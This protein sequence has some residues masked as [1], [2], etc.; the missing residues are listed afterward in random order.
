MGNIQTFIPQD[1]F[2]LILEYLKTFEDIEFH[3]FHNIACTSRFFSKLIPIKLLKCQYDLYYPFQKIKLNSKQIAEYMKQEKR[4]GLVNIIFLNDNKMLGGLNIGMYSSNMNGVIFECT[5]YDAHVRIDS[6][7]D[8]KVLNK[9][10]SLSCFTINNILKTVY[11]EKAYRRWHDKALNIPRFSN[12]SRLY[13]EWNHAMELDQGNY[14]P[15]IIYENEVKF[16]YEFLSRF[17]KEISEKI[18]EYQ[19]HE[20]I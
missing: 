12:I 4:S 5:H 8:D 9:L 7:F 2:E 18:M 11:D 13:L 17:K 14:V 1:I 16:M 10:T 19:L 15:Q 20:F 6:M 3:E